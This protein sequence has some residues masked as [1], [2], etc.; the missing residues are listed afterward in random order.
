MSKTALKLCSILLFLILI[1]NTVSISAV[2]V[3]VSEDGNLPYSES[4]CLSE[5]NVSVKDFTN[6]S[7]GVTEVKE[8][9]IITGHLGKVGWLFNVPKDGAYNIRFKYVPVEDGG[10][11]IERT[12]YIDGELPCDEVSSVVF[13]RTYQNSESTVKDSNGNDIRPMQKEHVRTMELTLRDPAEIIQGELVFNLSSGEHLLELEALRESLGI[14]EIIFVPVTKQLTYSEYIK[15][16]NK[17]TSKAEIITV[18]A[19]NAQYKSNSTI[20]PISDNNASATPQDPVKIRLNTIGA[21]KWNT[22]GQWIEWEIDVET[23][24][25][26]K[27]VPRFMQN[28]Y[29]GGYVTRRLEIDGKVPFAEAEKIRFN[30]EN[31]WQTKALGDKNQEFLFYLTKGTHSFKMYVTIRM[32]VSLFRP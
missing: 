31:A 29:D 7:D 23:D 2:A 8:N 15:R 17:E 30:Y 10:G 19:E 21:D 32:N 12:L 18:E 11:S 1:F 4:E 6:E 27:I 13:S 24:G 9:C 22:A 14:Y 28:A 3:N 20:Y 16:F 26:Y 25:L 5:I